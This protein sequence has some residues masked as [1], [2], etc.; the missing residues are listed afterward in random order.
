VLAEI[1][2][3]I[4]I[5][6]IFHPVV[7]APVCKEGFFVGVD[8]ISVGPSYRT[9]TGVQIVGYR[10]DVVE[11]DIFRKYRIDPIQQIRRIDRQFGI[12]MSDVPVRMHAGI[13]SST[14]GDLGVLPEDNTEGPFQHLLHAQGIF[15]PLP[16][17]VASTFIAEFDEIA[18]A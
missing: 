5:G 15:L 8:E 6:Q 1:I 7:I 16:S 18:Q 13:R 17:V 2:H 9:E 4:Q 3:Q 14:S 11:S 10:N 12:E